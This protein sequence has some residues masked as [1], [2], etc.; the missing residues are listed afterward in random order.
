MDTKRCI[1]ENMDV[2]GQW[3]PKDR[4]TKA[5]VE[6]C[7]KKRHV[8]RRR[9][10]YRRSTRPENVEI[11]NT[12]RRPQIGKK[13]EGHIAK[14]CNGFIVHSSWGVVSSLAIQYLQGT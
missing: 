5:E 12:M 4:K 9:I 2:D 1:N 7:Y 8:Q 14:T 11:E 3:T 6:R 13:I 10:K